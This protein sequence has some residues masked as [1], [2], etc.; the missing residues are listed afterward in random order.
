MSSTAF[1]FGEER[2]EAQLVGGVPNLLYL[3]AGR[4]LGVGLLVEGGLLATNHVEQDAVASV[5]ARH[6]W[7]AAP[8]L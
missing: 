8:V 6:M 1:G 2:T 7:H 5:I 4:A 3:L